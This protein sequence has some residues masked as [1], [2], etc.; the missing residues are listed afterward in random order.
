MRIMV[1]KS[2]KSLDTNKNQAEKFNS[3]MHRLSSK[4]S[5]YRFRVSALLLCLR[6]VLAFTTIGVLLYSIAIADRNLTLIGIGV[7]AVT[8][9]SVLIQ[10]MLSAKTRCPLCLTPVLSTKKCAKHRNARTLMGSHRLLVALHI[11]LRGNFVCPYCYERTAVEK[12][13]SQRSRH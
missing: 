5:V 2:K 8:L 4:S 12:R 13:V 1:S 11:L 7:G 10:W 3:E 6:C 9:F